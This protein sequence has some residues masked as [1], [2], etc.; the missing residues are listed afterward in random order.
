MGTYTRRTETVE[1]PSCCFGAEE[2]KVMF[3]GSYQQSEQRA[4]DPIHPRILAD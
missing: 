2:W 1:A 4:R 3:T